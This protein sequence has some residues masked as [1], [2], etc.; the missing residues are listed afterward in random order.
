MS[1]NGKTE[2][3]YLIPEIWSASMYDEL[4]NSIMFANLFSRQYEGEIKNVGDTVKVQQIQAPSAEILTDDKQQFA[5]SALTVS[6]FSIVANKRA[7]AAFEFTDLAQL[8]SLSFQQQAQEAL[9]YAIRLK[10]ESDIIAGLL[11][12]TSAPD[13]DIA[14]A[15]GP[16][17]AVDLG[18]MRTLLSTAKVPVSNRSLLLSPSYYGDLLNA[19][20]VTSMDFVN[21]NSAQSGVVASFMG[22]QIM[23]HNLLGND[24]GFAIHPSALQLVMQTEVRVKISD[25]HSQNKYG[26][27]LSADLV[28]GYTLADNRRICKISG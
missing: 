5:S 27:L 7:S 17:A 10:M 16:L 2:L 8:Q 1:V 18:T 22:F 6:Q 9:V 14:P 12:S 25:L 21:G 3:D 15:S 11:P 24:I 13:H 20:T 19:T 26:Y 23:E 4:R 28:Y